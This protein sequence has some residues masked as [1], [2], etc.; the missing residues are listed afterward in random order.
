M[1]NLIDTIS[2]QWDLWIGQ[3]RAFFPTGEEDLRASNALLPE[4]EQSRSGADLPPAP[5]RLAACLD[6]RSGE[7]IAA[8][9]LADANCLK[10]S[11]AVREQ[12]S[13][14]FFDDERLAGMAIITQQAIQPAYLKTPALTVLMS[15]CII[16][17]LKAGGETLVM[18]CD[19]GHF[20][21]Y[22]R[23]GFR[24]VGSLRKTS[25]GDYEIPMIFLP[26][27]DYL[28]IINSP[29]V[30]LLRGVNYER[31]Q[32][33]CQWYYRLV[34]ENSELQV[35]SA[36]Y[37]E[38]EEAFEGHRILT[39]GLSETGRHAFLKNAMVINCREGEVLMTENDGGKAFGFVRRG[40]VK[41]VIGSKTVVLL[42][43]GDIFGEIAFILH[44]KR[45]AEVVAA[46][47]DTEVVLLSESAINSLET[48][49]DRTVIWRNLA[50]I[51]A[52]RVV[53]TN[54][55]LD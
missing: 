5:Q 35:G 28:T 36:F 11:I 15:H 49:A 39:E 34:R 20:P 29:V 22:K 24:P 21:L 6:T 16:E 23:L 45:S 52:Q 40:L 31:Y 46:S 14:E 42:G 18:S 47:E 25:G 44:S 26:D 32:P 8:L 37:P 30:P 51:L 10:S 55:L 38:T 3:Y 43:E 50:R 41:V 54:K 12:Y 4:M 17:V 33:L 27:H 48:E 19:T 9:R 2:L 53:L 7:I 13:F 1:T